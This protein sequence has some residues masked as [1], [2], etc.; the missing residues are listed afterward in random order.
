MDA[1]ALVFVVDDDASLRRVL[2]AVETVAPT[3]AT[4]LLAGETGTGKGIDRT[5]HPYASAVAVPTPS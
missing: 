2:Q 1:E 3:D 5:R 4:V